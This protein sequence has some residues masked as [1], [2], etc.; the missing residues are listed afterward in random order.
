MGPNQT[1]KILHSK[2]KPGEKK[3][4]PGEK[5]YSMGENICKWCDGQGLNLQTI[6]TAHLIQ[7]Q[8]QQKQTKKWAE[9]FNGH[10]AKEDKQLAR[11]HMKRCSTSL[12]IREM[13]IKTSMR[14]YLTL[15]KMAIIKMSTNDKC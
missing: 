5:T 14:Y 11:R 10:F 1:D 7:W 6:Q 3:K 4:T 12:I 2:N 8:Q 13:Q 15:V 9:D